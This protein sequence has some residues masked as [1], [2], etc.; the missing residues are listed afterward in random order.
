LYASHYKRSPK[1][2]LW[3]EGTIARGTKANSY[4]NHNMQEEKQQRYVRSSGD[5]NSQD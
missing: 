3:Q 4:R 1:T 5:G 2:T